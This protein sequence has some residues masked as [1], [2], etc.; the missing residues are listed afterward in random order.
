MKSKVIG[1]ADIAMILTCLLW[2]LGTVAVKNVIGNSPEQFRIFVFNGIRMPIVSLLLFIWVKCKGGS[3]GL[4]LKHIPLII[5]VSFF[6]FFLNMVTSLIGLSMS[7]ASNM[8]IIFT[9]IPF[10]ILIISFLSGIEKPTVPL[11]F[12]IFI[13][14]A[15]VLMLSY[16]GSRISY[17]PGDMLILLSCFFWAIYTVYGKQLLNAYPPLLATAWVFL[18]A[19]IFQLPLFFIQLSHQTWHTITPINWFNFLYAAIGS[20]FFAFGL[21]FY[22]LHKIGP[23]RAG[24]YT[25]LE[26]VFTLIFAYALLGETITIFKISGFIIILTGIGITKIPLRAKPV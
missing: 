18:F 26:P 1:I 8:G 19:S 5:V 14:M 3:I 20:Y 17:N 7:T 11:V 23:I 6:G 16:D 15:G 10:F 24:I 22:A 13:G 21:Y 12:G 2:G 4:R 9:T 25:N